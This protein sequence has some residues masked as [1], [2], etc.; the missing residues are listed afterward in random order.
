MCLQ[1][2]LGLMKPATSGQQ[3]KP[4]A[5]HDAAASCRYEIIII[6]PCEIV[7]LL[8]MQENDLHEG[9]CA[10]FLFSLHLV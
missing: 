3:G 7:T 4:L 1:E 10:H 9:S 5:P 8:S 6:L 2:M